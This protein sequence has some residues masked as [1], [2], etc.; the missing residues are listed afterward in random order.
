MRNIRKANI[1]VKMSDRLKGKLIYKLVVMLLLSICLPVI[2]FS[3][4]SYIMSY[5]SMEQQYKENK[6]NLNR[7]IAEKVES[8]FFAL[9]GQ[10]NA[11]YDYE[12]VAYILTTDK[13]SIT[14]EYLKNYNQVYR[15]LVSIIQG[16]F[17]IDGISLV[18]MEGEIKFYYDR[19]MSRQNL[20]IVK[21]EDWYKETLDVSGRV[22]ILPPHFNTYADEG[23]VCLTWF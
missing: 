4:I 11:I 7:Q 15:N 17:N 10:A 19:D 23:K 21:E 22:V 16:N 6:D 5:K 18:N 3:Y 1:S 9:K 8:N 12:S 2:L 14:E 20:N 13:S